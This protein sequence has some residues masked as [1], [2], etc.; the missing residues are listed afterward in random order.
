MASTLL[1][2]VRALHYGAMV[3][4]AGTLLFEV[5][6]AEPV[7]RRLGDDRTPVFWRWCR[8]LTL[9]SAV[10]GILSGLLWLF[11]EASAMS[12]KPFALVFSQ[13]IVPMVLVR[14]HFGHDWLLRGM[15][16][17]PLIACIVARRR[18]T[19]S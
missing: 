15:L 3:S 11:F 8:R 7:L 17:L 18:S 14:T 2:V 13:G 1:T 16:A 4:L 9:A 5:C 19:P 6:V 12:G 10:L